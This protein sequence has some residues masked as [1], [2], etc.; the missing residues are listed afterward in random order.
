[1]SSY[2]VCRAA[3][4]WRS[5]QNWEPEEVSLAY[6]LFLAVF[7]M[8]TKYRETPGETFQWGRGFSPLVAHCVDLGSPGVRKVTLFRWN[9]QM[10]PVT[11]LRGTRVITPGL[12]H[13]YVLIHLE[14]YPIRTKTRIQWC[15]PW[16]RD[17]SK[18]SV[19]TFTDFT[20]MH[21]TGTL[22]SI[23]GF[24]QDKCFE[25]KTESWFFPATFLLKEGKVR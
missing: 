11:A 24:I 17:L 14:I 19:F 8:A 13:L 7:I 5:F 15:S 25:S 21:G 18:V 2:Q 3:A 9:K 16:L 6:E 10:H 20:V 1:M 12:L 4:A 23:P 22:P